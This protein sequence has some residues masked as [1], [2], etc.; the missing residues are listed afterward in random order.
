MQTLTRSA[1]DSQPVEA[2]DR[3]IVALDCP[4]VGQADELIARLGAS[5][6]FYKIGWRLFLAGGMPFVDAVRSQHKR[7]FLDLK[8]DDIAET[9][10]TAVAVLQNRADLLTLMG[11]P[12]TIRA[13][14]RG[15]GTADRPKLLSVTFLSSLDETDLREMLPPGVAP[16]ETQ[17]LPAHIDK[18]AKHALEAGADGVIA[19][20]ESIQS[21]RATLGPQPLIVT[22]GIRLPGSP[23]NDQKRT[24]TPAAAIVDGS[25]FLVVGRPIWAAVDPV[26]AAEAIIADIGVGIRQLGN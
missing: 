11:T 18:R 12:A 25:D 23:A 9:V 15:R 2:A 21:L 20:G 6:S 22:P 7:V 1:S 19:S 17:L 10:E 5:I 8:M 4:T 13:A 3:L 24:K 16:P 14:V 26:A